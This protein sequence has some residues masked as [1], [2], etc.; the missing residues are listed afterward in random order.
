M[1]SWLSHT[2][3]NQLKFDRVIFDYQTI[4]NFVTISMEKR[5]KKAQRAMK[6]INNWSSR[7][8]RNQLKFV[9]S[10]IIRR[11]KSLTQVKSSQFN[12]FLQMGL[13][14]SSTFSF[15]DFLSFNHPQQQIQVLLTAH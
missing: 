6:A 2:V 1:N 3:C 11:F 13:I 8:V 15:F 7:T 4:Y 5:E 12:L 9:L 14:I 10:L